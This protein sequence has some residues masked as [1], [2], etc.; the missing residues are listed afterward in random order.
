MAESSSS[1][2]DRHAARSS[3]PLTQDMFPDPNV[4]S[5]SSLIPYLS[6]ITEVSKSDR[7]EIME[8]LNGQ[9]LGQMYTV[10]FPI[11]TLA[12]LQH[13]DGPL[14]KACVLL[15][16]EPDVFENKQATG[17]IIRNRV[18]HLNSLKL[19]EIFK[20]S[21]VGSGDLYV[22][23][24]DQKVEEERTL[25]YQLVA[26]TLAFASEDYPCAELAN[27]VLARAIDMLEDVGPIGDGRYLPT[28]KA[29][30]RL[31]QVHKQL[32]I[33]ASRHIST[34]QEGP[35]IIS[36]KVVTDLGKMILKK[37]E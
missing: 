35:R 8:R 37:A 18:E 2:Y 19:L 31:V 23:I 3:L 33:L 6:P 17:T 10:I 22:R 26:W 15:T 11:L 1:S 9:Q 16:D 25:R 32:M 13:D 30:Q 7:D 21:T 14:F 29:L 5:S 12:F 4:I 34:K 24:P 27:S 20:S 36:A 28:Y